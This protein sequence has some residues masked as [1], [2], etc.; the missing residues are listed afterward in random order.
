MLATPDGVCSEHGLY[1]LSGARQE[2]F[3]KVNGVIGGVG[4]LQYYG[5]KPGVGSLYDIAVVNTLMFGQSIGCVAA[6]V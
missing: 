3:D 5:P 2:D 6:C 1:F 4:G